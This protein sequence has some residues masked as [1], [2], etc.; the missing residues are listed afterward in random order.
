MT[1][2]QGIF[3]P[4]YRR[5]YTTTAKYP[6]CLNRGE[7][8]RLDSMSSEVEKIHHDEEAKT[9]LVTFSSGLQTTRQ[10]F[11]PV[12]VEIPN[13]PYYHVVNVID[14]G[15]LTIY[16]DDVLP[17]TEKTQKLISAYGYSY[18]G[19]SF[20]QAVDRANAELNELLTKGG[21]RL[22]NRLQSQQKE[23]QNNAWNKKA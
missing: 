5:T 1:T 10:E 6:I 9:V 7:W 23:V 20:T 22:A 12:T 15:Y 13:P 8:V 21:N 4:T 2:F 16:T 3:L 17:S 18:P 11:E 19:S 14:Y